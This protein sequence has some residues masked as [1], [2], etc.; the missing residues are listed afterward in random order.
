MMALAGVLI[1]LGQFVARYDLVVAGLIVPESLG[2]DNVPTY[3]GYV[4]SVFEFGVVI[5]SISVVCF[6]FLMG[7]RV[8]GKIFTQ[9]EHH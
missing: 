2:W 4:P 1:L 8:F 9:K 7:E 3:L 5:G 6:G